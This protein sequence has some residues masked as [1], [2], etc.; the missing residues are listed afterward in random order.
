MKLPDLTGWIP[1]RIASAQ[2]APAVEWCFL[3]TRRF[4]ESF[5]DHTIDACLREPFNQLFRHQT[6]IDA[7]LEWQAVRPGIAPTGFIFHMS[8]CGSTLVAQML[9][10]LEKNIV[11]SEAPP[12]DAILRL[13]KKNP[14]VT[15][16][17]RIAWLRALVS[18]L[19]QPRSGDEK[20]LFIK[21]DSWHTLDI[22]LI[23][24]AFPGVPW[25]FLYREPVEV[26]ISQIHMRGLGLI[27]GSVDFEIPGVDVAAA[28]QMPAEEYCARALGRICQAAVQ[29]VPAHCGK[30]I[31]YRQLPDAFFTTICDAFR[32][33]FS[34]SE[35]ER[36][37]AVTQFDAKSPGM[38]FSSDSAAKQNLATELLRQMTALH[39]A[40]AYE[41]LEAARQSA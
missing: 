26:M 8:R 10:A 7:L 29:N 34:E 28:A 23:R 6:P 17:Q 24:R 25:I 14:H 40:P 16:D 1:V 15:D 11:L 18:A 3:G 4:T 19:A 35:I 39:I 21:F 27:P 2:T 31:N 32:V 36:M 33:S 5:F 9:A 38:F 41:Q 20:N 30:L 12:V 37:R 22:P 13:H